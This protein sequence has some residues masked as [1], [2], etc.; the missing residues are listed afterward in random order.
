MGHSHIFP[1]NSTFSVFSN[2]LRDSGAA[3]GIGDLSQDKAVEKRLLAEYRVISAALDRL[4]H[5]YENVEAAIRDMQSEFPTIIRYF[6]Y[7][8]FQWW[9]EEP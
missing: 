4:G 6:R 9:V 1:S 8:L 3:D 7:K 2:I 5:G